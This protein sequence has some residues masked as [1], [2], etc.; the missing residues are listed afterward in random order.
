VPSSP[1][2][3]VLKTLADELGDLTKCLGSP[4]PTRPY[5]SRS[6]S[7]SVASSVGSMIM[8]A[9]GFDSA[10]D[11]SSIRTP[12]SA[13]PLIPTK[14]GFEPHDTQGRRKF[15]IFAAEDNLIARRLLTALFTEQKV[16][17]PSL[18]RLD[19]R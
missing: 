7:F 13:S 10:S 2:A 12:P 14:L 15:T 18:R 16:S 5:I 11:E 9:D 1:A 17:R 4:Q 6:N 3:P 8:T 19:S